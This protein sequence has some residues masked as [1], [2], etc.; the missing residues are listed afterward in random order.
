M[1]YRF[2]TARPCGVFFGRWPGLWP[3]A[4]VL[5]ALGLCGADFVA[6]F[7]DDVWK[8]CRISLTI[9]ASLWRIFRNI[10]SPFIK[11]IHTCASC[12]NCTRGQWRPPSDGRDYM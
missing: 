6:V 5:L 11:K 8:R 7:P 9:L 2:L 4:R 3:L 1:V 10:L 12:A